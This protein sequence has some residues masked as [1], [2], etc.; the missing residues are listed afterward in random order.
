MRGAQMRLD[1]SAHNIANTQTED[2]RP[3]QV[4]QTESAGGGVDTS[5]TR[6]SQAGESLEADV[7]AQLQAKNTFL[8]NLSVFRT[9]DQMLGSLLDTKA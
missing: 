6:A 7:V 9:G 3:Q 2:F 5:V 1:A 4:V 8:A